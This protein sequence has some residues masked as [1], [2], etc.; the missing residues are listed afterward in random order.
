MAVP[1][2]IPTS[3]ES[4]FLLLHLLASTWC[5][6]CFGFLPFYKRCSLTFK[7]WFNLPC[8]S[9]CVCS[10][11]KQEHPTV[12]Q[13]V[14][15]LSP[16]R[17]WFQVCAL[18]FL[19]MKACHLLSQTIFCSSPRDLLND[20]RHHFSSLVVNVSKDMLVNPRDTAN[21]VPSLEILTLLNYKQGPLK[22]LLMT[23]DVFPRSRIKH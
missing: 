10:F 18:V 9:K 19:H 6:Q 21:E 16:H 1:F 12:V 17:P 3:N 4:E 23:L 7:S 5:G 13:L 8:L 22:V 15:Q 11:F 2:C 14:F 20:T